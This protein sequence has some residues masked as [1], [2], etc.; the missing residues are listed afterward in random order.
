MCACS[1]KI[2]GS[3]EVDGEPFVVESCKSGQHN[4]FVGVDF[5]DA[6]GRRL[7]LAMTPSG[8]PNIILFAGESVGVEFGACGSLSVER[9]NSTINDI[10]NVRGTTQIACKGDGHQITGSVTIENCH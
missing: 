2:E 9:Q 3:L 6:K 10:T 4:G 5:L 1:N 8:A 7:R